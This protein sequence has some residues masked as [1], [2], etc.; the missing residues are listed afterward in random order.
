[1]HSSDSGILLRATQNEFAQIRE[2]AGKIHGDVAEVEAED[3]L[4]V[5]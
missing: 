1:M 5:I 4:D 2:T 3:T